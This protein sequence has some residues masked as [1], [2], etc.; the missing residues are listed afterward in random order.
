M[1]GENWNNTVDK[2][3]QGEITIEDLKK[4]SDIQQKVYTNL[5]LE[6]SQMYKNM[7]EAHDK[8]NS[9]HENIQNIK[10]LILL[11]RAIEL[12]GKYVKVK[13]NHIIYIKDIVVHEYEDPNVYCKSCLYKLSDGKISEGHYCDDDV[14]FLTDFEDSGMYLNINTVK[15]SSEYEFNESVIMIS[16]YLDSLI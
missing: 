10:S 1:L 3:I 5:E 12:K 14:L 15:E 16:R 4:E 2:V 6:I 8:L 11:A 7:K 9:I 13:P